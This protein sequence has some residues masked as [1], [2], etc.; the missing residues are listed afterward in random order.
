MFKSHCSAILS[1][2]IARVNA[3]LIKCFKLSNK[4][5]S[6]IFSQ[7]WNKLTDEASVSP[8]EISEAVFLVV[9]DPCMNEL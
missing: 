1:A 9:C 6:E 2:K 8:K 3:A 4:N 7:T 5:I